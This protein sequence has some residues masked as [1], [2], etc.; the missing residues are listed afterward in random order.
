MKKFRIK[1]SSFSKGLYRPAKSKVSTLIRNVWPSY[2]YLHWF[3]QGCRLYFP[4]KFRPKSA[5]GIG[6]G[7]RA[8]EIFGKI[9]IKFGKNLWIFWIRFV[10]IGNKIHLNYE[11]KI[12]RHFQHKRTNS[13]F[14]I[15]FNFYYKVYRNSE[16]KIYRHFE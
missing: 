3:Q 15:P 8:T 13:E 14:K 7:T 11:Y 10:E 16:Y 4:K 2:Q 12:Y 1:L 5:W 6:R 9:F